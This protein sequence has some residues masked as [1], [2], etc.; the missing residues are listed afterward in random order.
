MQRGFNQSR[1]RNEN[2]RVRGSER[3]LPQ[4]GNIT[5]IEST[6]RENVD[7]I[8][9]GMNLALPER[10][11][12]FNANYVF[13][14]TLNHT[15]SALQL[16]ADNDNLEAEW[17]PSSQD[18]R[19]RLF[20]MT[21]VGL[22]RGFRTMVMSQASSALPYTVISGFDSNG[23]GVTNDRPVGVGRNSARGVASWNLNVRLAKTFTFGPPRSDTPGTGPEP[24]RLRGGQGRG[25]GGPGL[26]GDGRGMGG[27]MVMMGG[28]PEPGA[29]RYGIELYAQAYN[30]LNRVNYTRFSGNLLSPFFGKPTAA[31]QARR[32]EVGVMFG[33]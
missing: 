24:I 9:V 17:S 2:A 32:L 19:H 1:A 25:D 18:A 21:S 15:D 29:G 30:V 3:P 22:P 23:D 26:R 27:N 7:R 33:F 6:G 5:E 14:R 12:F 28:P 31:A 10:R 11:L 16:P 4:F 13:S 8:H 20:V